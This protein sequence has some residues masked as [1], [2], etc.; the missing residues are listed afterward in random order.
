MQERRS[1]INALKP[2]AAKIHI[3]SFTLKE[4]DTIS[5]H[6]RMDSMTA[7]SWRVESATNQNLTAVSKEIWKYLLKRM[8]SILPNN[9]QCQGM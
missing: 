7:L 8:I 4:R 5:V 3:M 2:K 9:Y 6:I 1:H